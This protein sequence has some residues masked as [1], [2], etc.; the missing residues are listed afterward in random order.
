[1]TLGLV[2]QFLEDREII[3]GQSTN[4]VRAYRHDLG[5]FSEFANG[6]ND[7]KNLLSWLRR[8]GLS[9]RSQARLISSVK[10]YFRFVEERGGKTPDLQKL[11]PP[12][13][14]TK[15]PKILTISEFNKILEASEVGSED[16]TSR[17]RITLLMLF[18]LG[19]RVSELTGLNLR[20]W[21]ESEKWVSIFGKGGNERKVP[22][23]TF[24]NQELKKYVEETRPFLSE[25]ETEALLINDRGHR[26]SRVDVWRW[27]DAW[28]K[29]AKLSKRVG[30][31]HFRHGCATALL[32]SGADL[33]TIQ[34]LLGH[35]SL[36]T[37]KIYASV[38]TKKL[39]DTIDNF[40]PMSSTGRAVSM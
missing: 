31:H 10:E 14:N 4:T 11:N 32:E 3:R 9:A 24:L 27:I 26:P 6:A 5:V 36:E 30:P 2:D 38:S 37:T 1:M 13:F 25:A 39:A 29:K 12:K 17:N 35:S 28:S 22:L 19:C 7:F 21:H 34:K 16:K 15:L 33:R 20:S 18:G 8:R 40:H 23:T